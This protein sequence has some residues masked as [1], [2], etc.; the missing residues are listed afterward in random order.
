MI[1]NYISITFMNIHCRLS[2]KE[3]PEAVLV[4]YVILNW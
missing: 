1:R 3:E 2:N 4:S